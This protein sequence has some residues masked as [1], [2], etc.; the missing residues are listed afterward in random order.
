MPDKTHTHCFNLLNFAGMDC[1][2]IDYAHE[3][4]GF[5]TWHRQFVLWFEWEIQWMLESMGDQ[6]YYTF[7]THY[8][9][10]RI[11]I[12]MANDNI[13]VPNRLGERRNSQPQVHGDLFDGGWDTICW[14]GGSGNVSM[15]KGT[16]CDP[17]IKTG[18]LLRCP[19]LGNKDPCDRNNDWPTRAD[20]D[21]ALNKQQYDTQSYDKYARESFRNFMEG[22]DSSV[23]IDDCRSDPQCFCEGRPDCTGDN[24]GIPLKI[25]LHNLVSTCSYL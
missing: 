11:E 6:N 2:K 16:T 22:Y 5:P 8:W 19:L 13:F 1:L 7:R 9:D 4:T 25:H 15:P 21:K 17:R 12:Q 3:A 18:P 14:Y 10:W 23:S 20:V 24:P